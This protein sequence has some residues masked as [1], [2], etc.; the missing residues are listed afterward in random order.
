MWTALVTHAHQV[1]AAAGIA[2]ALGLPNERWGSRR[3]ALGWQSLF[4]LKWHIRPLQPLQLL[5]R[6]LRVPEI[7]TAP[8]LTAAWND[9]W[10]GR[11][12]GDPAVEVTP[13]QTAGAAFDEIWAAR[14]AARDRRLISVVRDRAWVQW[15][16]LDAPE[17]RYHL[18]LARREGRPVGYA[19]C[20]IRDTPRGRLGI[21]ADLFISCENSYADDTDKRGLRGF[22]SFDQSL[23][24][25]LLA[26]AIRH[27]I[28]LNAN[29]V[30]AL[31]I[32]GSPLARLLERAGFRFSRGTFD[33]R[34]VPFNAGW[35]AQQLRQPGAWFLTGSEFDVV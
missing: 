25:T 27:F 32:P 34:A 31:A 35:S 20:A 1:W 14:I 13:V 9:F 21:I 23:Y 5:A 11:L 16:F 24:G 7:I 3:E 6:R 17:S 28:V 15:R 19:A 4:G 29:A 2:F 33:V 18:L 12:S 26:L 30:A 10:T 22:S 8:A